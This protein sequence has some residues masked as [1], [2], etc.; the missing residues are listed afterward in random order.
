[1]LINADLK[2]IE[3]LVLAQLCKDLDLIK[4]LNQGKDLHK[5][6]ASKLYNKK[7]EDVTDEERSRSKE[8]TF[9]LSYGAGANSIALKT[10]KNVE[11]AKDFISNFY[12]LFPDVKN[13]HNKIQEEVKK[14]SELVLFTGMR[15]KFKQYPAKYD[16]Q[17]PNKLYYNPPEI[18]NYPVQ[19][20][21][22]MIMAILAGMFYRNYAVH[23]RN[24]YLLINTVHDSLMLDCKEDFID[25]AIED[26]IKT[27]DKVSE[28]IYTLFNERLIV[29]LKID[30]SIGDRW[31]D[32]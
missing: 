19:H 27:L 24:K 16:W 13:W 17:D 32:L 1:M 3:V 8:A 21:A 20:I 4:L 22:G 6:S 25:E 11:W 10:D 14:T 23:K 5:F 2:Q 28:V 12:S 29:P 26:I 30:V 9:E 18:K 31:S 15:L 7:E